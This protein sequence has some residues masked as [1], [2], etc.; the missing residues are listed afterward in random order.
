[1]DS[2]IRTNIDE[3]IVD[4]KQHGLNVEDPVSKL[5]VAA[6]VYQAQKIKDEISELPYRML[7]RI[8]S[9]YI[10]KNKLDA[11]PALC[12]VQPMV[13]NRKD[14][15]AHTIGNGTCFMYKIDSKLNLS[16]YPLYR[17]YFIPFSSLHIVSSKFMSTNGNH[18]EINVPLKGLVWLGLES[19]VD[20]D[21]LECLSLFIKGTNGVLPKSIYVGDNMVELSYTTANNLSD[22]PM[23]EPFDAQQTNPS[24]LEVFSNWKDTI[25]NCE[26]G[27]LIYITDKLKDRDVFKSKAFPNSFQ[28]MMESCDLEKFE[29]NTLW[30]LLDF[31]NGFNVPENLDII[32]NVVPVVNVCLNTA[33]LTQSSPIVKLTKGDGSFFLD[34]VETPITAQKQGFNVLSE[35]VIIRDFDSTCF[36][37][38]I[39][40]REVRNLFNRFVDDYHAFV[41]YYELKDGE[42]LRSF[43]DILNK[44][45]KSVEPRHDSRNKY[46]E[47]TYAMR[48]ISL[49]TQSSPIVVSYLTTF[50]RLGNSPKAGSMMANKKDAAIDRDVPVIASATGGEDKAGADL[51]YELLRYHTLTSDRLFTKKDIEA[52]LR[53]QLLKEFGKEEIKRIGYEVSVQGAAGCH[54]LVRG[55]YISIK[56]KDEKNYNTA[57]GMAFDRKLKR[58]IENKSC[59]SMPI[60]V[61]LYHLMK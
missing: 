32:P 5:I 1:M 34:V 33:T 22:I 29:K 47:G 60:F 59:V 17:N 46:K 44:I 8:S 18:T 16:Y 61:D 43:R 21:S 36:N 3:L 4:L 12:Y 54:K 45:G 57:T 27:T 52:F 40:H 23:M 11:I 9:C 35:D 30:I 13:K 31:G 37:P 49:K 25:S 42:L 10:P 15:G 26:E 55:L 20:T 50:G 6:L 28:H 19:P 53:L 2:I 38:D 56:F 14:I 58:M 7:D 39:L 41:D 51:N 24:M 48:K